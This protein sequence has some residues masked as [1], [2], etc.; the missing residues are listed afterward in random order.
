MNRLAASKIQ[1]SI[2]LSQEKHF[3]VKGKLKEPNKKA[4]QNEVRITDPSMKYGGF[5]K[6]ER[7]FQ[8]GV[9]PQLSE[10][11]ILSVSDVTFSDAESLSFRGGFPSFSEKFCL[12]KVYQVKNTENMKMFSVQNLPLFK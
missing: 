8:P 9:I 10:E 12:L 6:V 5:E 1:T 4:K 11:I 7:V 2:N 3:N